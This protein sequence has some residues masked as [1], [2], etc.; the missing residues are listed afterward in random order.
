MAFPPVRDLPVEW[1]YSSPYYV[2]DELSD[3]QMHWCFIGDIIENISVD[4]PEFLVRD[5]DGEVATVVLEFD[6]WN[7]HEA[8]NDHFSVG[9]IFC[10][11]YAKRWQNDDGSHEIRLGDGETIYGME[12]R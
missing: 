5:R 3:P 12:I 7:L 1:V 11:M 10:I 4:G 9:H 2:Q 6:D 8:W